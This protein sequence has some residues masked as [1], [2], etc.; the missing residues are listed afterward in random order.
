MKPA[1]LLLLALAPAARAQVI[2][3][4]KFYPWEDT[5]LAEVPH[6]HK[7]KGFVAKSALRGAGMYGGELRGQGELQGDAQKV[8]GGWD[9]R[10]GF[11]P[12]DQKWLVCTYGGGDVTWWEQIDP[13]VTS[14]IVKTRGSGRDPLDVKATC[15]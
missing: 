6:Q 10:H 5:P 15:S 7:G 3:C 8:R 13:K 14:C 2:E 9:V 12:G 1:L 11:A 4:P